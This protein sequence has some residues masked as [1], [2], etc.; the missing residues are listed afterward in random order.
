MIPVSKTL[1]P[2]GVFSSRN[3]MNLGD[4]VFQSTVTAMAGVGPA[5]VIL[6]LG[7][8]LLDA[9][10]ALKSQGLRFF[11]TSEWDPVFEKFGA[12]HYIYGTAVTSLLALVIA[13]PIAVGA[14]LFLAEYAAKWLRGPVGYLIEMLAV[15][16]SIIYGLWGFFILAPFMRGNV[17]PFLKEVI[18]PLPIVGSMF[19][20]P[21]IGK[22]LLVAG[23]ILAI[24]ILPTVTA[25]SREIIRAVPDTQRE[26][27]IALGA[28]KWEMISVAV[29]PY[30]RSGIIG[31]V[32]LGLGRAFG[33]TMAVT[34]VIGNSSS[35]ISPSLFTP[36]YTMASAIANQFTEA[37]T[38]MYFSAVVGVAFTLLIVSAV[39]NGLARILIWRVARGPVGL[40]I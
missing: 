28:T 29:L 22:D 35:A 27:M 3:G 39:M 17:E 15:I 7:L 4:R 38:E 25:I 34:L 6:L 5:L 30:A 2:N 24:M 32:M 37:D 16:P 40:R 9:W 10:P 36:G 21:A 33:E 13:T 19:S 18:G 12:A 8:L 1:P 20:G 14:A 26:G 23:V 11:T 31:A